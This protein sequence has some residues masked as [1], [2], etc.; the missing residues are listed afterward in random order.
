MKR[1][2]KPSRRIHQLGRFYGVGVGPG[3]PELLTLKA[4]RVLRGVDVVFHAT[5]AR[6]PR[7]VSGTIL[8][9]AGLRRARLV[10]LVF[11]MSQSAAV[12]ARAWRAHAARVVGEL[13]KGRA[14]A[15]VT[16]GDPLLYGTYTYLLREIRRLAPGV[17]V[18]TVPGITSFQAAAAQANLPLAEDREVLVV[19]PAWT[20]ALVRHPALALADTLVL[21]KTYRHRRS[22][23]RALA[24]LGFREGVYA[25]RLGLEGERVETDLARLPELPQEYLS[26]VIARRGQE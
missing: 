11:T 23:A 4:R 24:K 16:I 9:Q 7:S 1:Q 8:R 14:C 2:N 19:A 18:E 17:A 13:R 22:L 6:S 26:L 20:P 3:D 15:F 10:P 21:L 12:R 25:A 5:G